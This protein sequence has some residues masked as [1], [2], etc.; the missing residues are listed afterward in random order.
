MP[1]ESAAVTML[2]TTGGWYCPKCGVTTPVGNVHY[3]GSAP[4]GSVTVQ[5]VQQGWQ[6]PVCGAVYAPW[7]FSCPSLNHPQKVATGANDAN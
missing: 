3:C 7:V 4:G 6:C 5:P 2:P 1:S